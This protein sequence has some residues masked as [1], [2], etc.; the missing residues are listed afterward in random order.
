[1]E[2]INLEPLQMEV[3]RMIDGPD[4][5]DMTPEE[6]EQWYKYVA[7]RIPAIKK[8]ALERLRNPPRESLRDYIEK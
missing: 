8:R 5:F 7:E 4:I 6:Y 1:M 3:L 2:Q